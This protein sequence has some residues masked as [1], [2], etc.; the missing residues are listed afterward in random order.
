MTAIPSGTNTEVVNNTT[1]TITTTTSSSLLSPNSPTATATAGATAT[2]S[3]IARSKSGADILFDKMKQDQLNHD[4]QKATNFLNTIL[5]DDDDHNTCIEVDHLHDE[6]KDGV[7]LCNL[8]NKLRPGTIKHV[9]QRDL[10]FIKMDNITR[11]LQGAR[12]LGLNDSQLFE[13]IDLFEA[14]DIPAVIHTIL[15]IAQMYTKSIMNEKELNELYKKEDEMKKPRMNSDKIY[16]QKDKDVGDQDEVK[17]KHHSQP[18]SK[19]M[20]APIVIRSSEDNND[21]NNGNTAGQDPISCDNVS[22]I[23]NYRD[24]REIFSLSPTVI[25]TSSLSLQSQLQQHPGDNNNNNSIGIDSSFVRPPKSPLRPTSKKRRSSHQQES[26]CH[27][28]TEDLKLRRPSAPAISSHNRPHNTNKTSCTLNNSSNSMCGEGSIYLSRRSSASSCHSFL[29]SASSSE[30]SETPLTPSSATLSANDDSTQYRRQHRRK[31]ATFAAR[32]HNP[33][34]S[35]EIQQQQ[36]ESLGRKLDRHLL[37][38][39][40]VIKQENG[41]TKG[42]EK[43][44]LKSKDGLT[45]AQYQLGNCIGKGQFGSVYRA[46]DMSTG[47]TVAVKRIQLDDAELDKEIMVNV[48]EVS[49]LKTLGHSNVIQYLG[50]I[51]SKHHMNIV[52]EYAENGSLMSTLKAFG[53]FPEKLVASF[54]IKILNGLEYLHV[55]EVVHCDLKAAN[56]LTTKTGDVKLSDFGVSLNLKIKASDPGS[57]SG[58]PNWMAPEVI[59]LKGA[60]TKS[61]IWS[62]GCTLIELVTGKPPYAD[63]I[64]MSAMFR[65]VEDNYPPLPSNIS[66]DMHSFLLCCFQKDPKERPTA[67]QLKEHSWIRANQRRLKKN[68]QSSTHGISSYLEQHKRSHNKQNS[69]IRPASSSSDYYHSIEQQQQRPSTPQLLFTKDETL[70]SRT[71][72]M[73]TNYHYDTRATSPD[74]GYSSKI[75]HDSGLASSVNGDYTTHQFIQTSFGKVVECKVCGDLTKSQAIFCEVCALICHKDC[76]KLAFS[77]PPK[78]KDQQPSYDWIFSAKI[79]N[80]S[81]QD[82]SGSQD[83][84]QSTNAVQEISTTWSHQR[85]ET[86]NISLENHPQA[87][88]IRKYSKALGLTPQEQRA[89]IENQALLSHTLALQH[90]DP[91]AVEKLLKN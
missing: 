25:T 14:K 21:S 69:I 13:T 90:M 24:V 11:F 75:S 34:H 33:S 40:E 15:V 37:K 55:N 47:E 68:N 82:R 7:L 56:I 53:S 66:Q 23:C 18:V 28:T 58:T 60:S 19:E 62:L 1:A 70:S 59:E 44:L 71:N 64:A 63:M 84:T 83:S 67:T 79:Y 9:G 36:T 20:N 12:Q 5:I 4:K 27:K 10:S 45:R 65:I 85:H 6:L 89:L 72:T 32:H 81:N 41:G 46:L 61:D 8:V 78:V 80:R 26:L 74:I 29:S 42:R 17:E 30:S 2:Q 38:S 31:S 52:L 87:E 76:K 16:Q 49:L 39:M 48:K 22:F 88:S 77:C 91:K 3:R 73:S 51:R 57:V 86:F 43:L 50:F 35:D 54:C